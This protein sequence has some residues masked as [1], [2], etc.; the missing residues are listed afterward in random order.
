MRLPHLFS[1]ALTRNSNVSINSNGSCN[2]NLTVTIN[3][4]SLLAVIVRAGRQTPIGSCTLQLEH[5]QS[6]LEAVS[7]LHT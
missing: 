2:L 3:R 6:F 4:K 7:I 5:W 1:P